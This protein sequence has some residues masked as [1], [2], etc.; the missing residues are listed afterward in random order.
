M[1]PRAAPAV[2]PGLL[3]VGAVGAVLVLLTVADV[4]ITIFNFDGFTFL[5]DRFHHVLWRALRSVSSV[6]PTRQRGAVLSLAAAAML[7]ATIALWLGLEITGFAMMFLP[8]VAGGDFVMHHQ[9]QGATG[10]AFYLSAGDITSL[11]FGDI[12]AKTSLYEALLDLETIVGL[13]TMTLAITY[14]LTTLGVLE[15]IDRLHGRVRRNAED[16]ERPSSV[17]AQHFRSPTMSQLPTLLQ[18]LTDDLDRYEQ[19]LRRY[20]VVYYFHTRRIERSVPRVFAALGEL[21]ALAR[22]GLPGDEPLTGDP[23]LRALSRE[24]ISAVERMQRNFIDTPEQPLR[25]PL[26][27]EEFW[28][29]RAGDSDDPGV[30]A[31]GELEVE[32]RRSAGLPYPPGA[33]TDPRDTYERYCEWLPFAERRQSFVRDVARSL[34][35]EGRPEPA[36]VPML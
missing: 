29:A 8:G 31:F 12:E 34:G 5:A 25:A 4:F 32:A 13:A 15:H 23:S 1:G 7:P 28:R 26:S 17:L 9:L 6:L 18:A 22:W 24:Y 36:D 27:E 19:G 35:Y 30:R 11:V 33:E 2:G 14:V 3:A 10:T 21:I 16:P 20:P